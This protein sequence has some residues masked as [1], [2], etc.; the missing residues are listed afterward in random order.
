M[1]LLDILRGRR[2]ELC[3]RRGSDVTYWRRE[4]MALCP[5]CRRMLRTSDRSRPA[6]GGR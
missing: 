2:C 5:R 4:A 6:G 1:N 3:A